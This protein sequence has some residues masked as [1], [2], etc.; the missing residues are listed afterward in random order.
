MFANT[1]THRSQQLTC[2]TPAEQRRFIR[3][4]YDEKLMPYFMYPPTLLLAMVDI[5]ELRGRGPPW[6]TQYHKIQMFDGCN[7][8]NVEN[9]EVFDFEVPIE[10]SLPSPEALLAQIDTFDPI[11]W[12]ARMTTLVQHQP[13]IIALGQLFQTTTRLFCILSL[14]SVGLLPSD[15]PELELEKALYGDKLF[16]ILR[17]DLHSNV[18]T[19]KSCLFSLAVAG[20]LAKE[21]GEEDRMYVKAECEFLSRSGG[22]AS[23]LMLIVA[24][25]AFWDKGDW[26]GKGWDDCFDKGYA[27]SIC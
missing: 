14:Q 18:L 20:F 10:E 11:P 6:H 8:S 4:S 25:Q 5:N 16:A 12:A 22:Q 13:Q 26:A 9:N 2:V 17:A 3:H 19:E 15:D 21:R 23:P 7:D 1:V 24:L 27:L